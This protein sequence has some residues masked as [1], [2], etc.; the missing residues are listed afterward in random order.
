MVHKILALGIEAGRRFTRKDSLHVLSI[1]LYIWPD[2]RATKGKERKYMSYW[3]LP[4][5]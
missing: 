3:P 5:G 4:K 1:N 2:I